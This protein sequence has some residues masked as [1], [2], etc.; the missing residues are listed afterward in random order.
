MTKGGRVS[1][2]VVSFT[3]YKADETEGNAKPVLF[4]LVH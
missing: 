3:Y 1:P 2:G 4:P